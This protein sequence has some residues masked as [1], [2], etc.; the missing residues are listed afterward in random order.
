MGG[1]EFDEI[2]FNDNWKKLDGLCK[3]AL[4]ENLTFEM[5]CGVIKHHRIPYSLGFV[6]KL[7]CERELKVQFISRTK[8][9]CCY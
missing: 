6:Q 5:F 3:I 1:F 9:G 7:C 8:K 4:K 2:S